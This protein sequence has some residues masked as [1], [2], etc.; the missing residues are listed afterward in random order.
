M[1][2]NA[3]KTAAILLLLVGSFSSCE[4]NENEDE[5]D[6]G[7]KTHYYWSGGQKI[8]LD[9]DYSVMI[10]RFDNEQSLN[11]Y[12]SSTAT[13]VGLRTEPPIALVHRQSKSDK[14]T[15]RK[16][17]ANKSVIGKVFG[18]LYHN[19]K[20]YF[21]LTGEIVLESKEG[22]SAENILREFRIDGEIIE[23][24]WNTVIQINNWDAIFDIANAIY[25]SGMVEYCHPNFWAPI[26]PW[27]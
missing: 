25:E 15:F 7:I 1:K 9:T 2:V 5:M 11:E 20:T 27:P 24:K 21:R 22:I 6:I 16:L 10:V 3:L 13:A 12:L 4:R 17:D 18:N 8:W 19:S 14:E 26:N 23:N